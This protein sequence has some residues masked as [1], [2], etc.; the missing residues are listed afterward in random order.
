V[1]LFSSR[2]KEICKKALER[3]LSLHRWLLG[4]PGEGGFVYREL[5]E[6]GNYLESSAARV[7]ESYVQDGCG[8]GY[9]CP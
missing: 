9:L 5:S 2:G 8:N 4:E 3:G 6:T 1:R 7:S